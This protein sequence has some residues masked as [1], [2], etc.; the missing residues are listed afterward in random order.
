MARCGQVHLGDEDEGGDLVP[1]EET[2]EGFGVGLDPVSA[3]DDQD[4]VVQDLEGALHLG[5]EVHVARGVQEGHRQVGGLKDS[6]L[7]EDGD[8]PGPLQGV[9][10]QIGIPVVHPAQLL[11]GPGGVEQ[12]FGQGGLARVHVGQDADDKSFHIVSP[13]VGVGFCNLYIIAEKEKQ[14]KRKIV[15]DG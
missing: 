3:A 4:G 6:L 7:G 11:D 14:G 9:S 2:P 5:G 12:G 10:V 13:R 1:A 8:A 15:A